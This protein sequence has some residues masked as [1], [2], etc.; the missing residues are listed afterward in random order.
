MNVVS[1]VARLMGIADPKRFDQLALQAPAGAGGVTVLPEFARDG[2]PADLAHRGMIVGLGADVSAEQLARA[3]IEGLVC[4]LLEAFDA[5]RSADVPVGGRL[6]LAGAG[7][8]SRAVQRV[9]A[10]L[11]ER[12]IIVAPGNWVAAGAA[13]QAAAA[14]EDRSPADLAGFWNLA[15][16]GELEPDAAADGARVRAQFRAARGVR[17]VATSS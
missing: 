16:R 10:D 2:Q 4:R 3:T 6:F 8:R 15:P 5:L 11:A 14:L 7:A 12:P 13:V 9:V 17:P 1:T